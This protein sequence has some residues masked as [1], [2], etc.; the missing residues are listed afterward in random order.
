VGNLNHP[1]FI[2]L[3]K[4]LF[5][6]KQAYSILPLVEELIELNKESH[7]CY[8]KTAETIEEP[9]YQRMF[10]SYAHYR[11]QFADELERQAKSEL[12][13]VAF[14][15]SLL[16]SLYLG[17]MNE[18]KPEL[19]QESETLTEEACLRVDS[20]ILKTYEKALVAPLPVKLRVSIIRQHAS[21]QAACKKIGSFKELL[22]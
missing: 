5:M 20:Q 21:I 16:D 14:T 4:Y 12:G 6:T 11:K 15:E 19:D 3:L 10:F 7:Y 13:Q 18:T 9:V 1:T 8:A 17:W 2:P 22:T